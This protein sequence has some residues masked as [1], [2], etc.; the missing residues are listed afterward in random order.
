MSADGH[1]N[2][3]PHGHKAGVPRQEKSRVEPLNPGTIPGSAGVPPACRRPKTGRPGAG[4]RRRDASAPKR[5]MGRSKLDKMI[6]FIACNKTPPH[7]SPAIRSFV[8]PAKFDPPLAEQA[9]PSNRP[10]AGGRRAPVIRVQGGCV[11]YI[12][13][14]CRNCDNTETMRVTTT[15]SIS[16]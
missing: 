12:T 13:G 9:P 11:T 2:S 7:G 8:K 6:K 14:F 10:W 15:G 5:F 4:T 1:D 16:G 3:S